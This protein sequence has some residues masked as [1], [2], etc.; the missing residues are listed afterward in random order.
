MS[1]NLKY[2]ILFISAVPFA[3]RLRSMLIAALSHCRLFE[4]FMQE[5]Q[6]S[7]MEDKQVYFLFRSARILWK[8]HRTGSTIKAVPVIK[9]RVGT[10]S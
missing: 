2:K 1:L 6:L 4:N 7:G 5:F 3:S 10:A 8:M 9:S